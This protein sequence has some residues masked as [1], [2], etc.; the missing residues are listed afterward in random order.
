MDENGGIYLGLGLGLSEYHHVPKKDNSQK[1]NKRV[2]F[3]NLSTPHPQYGTSSDDHELGEDGN[4]GRKNSFLSGKKEEDDDDAN[5]TNMN[6][7]RKK[8]RLTKDQITLLEES[9]KHHPTLN[10]AQ[11]QVLAEKSN[12]KPRQVEVWF[13]NRRAR[14]KLKQ[15]EVDCELL[16]KNCERLS[17]ENW[18]LKKE[19]LELRSSMKMEKARPPTPLPLPFFY[20]ISKAAA[21]STCPSCGGGKQEVGAAAGSMVVVREPKT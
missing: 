2:F 15:T 8:L 18:K 1:N 20:H 14:T 6:C 17:E 16:K 19:L 7:S 3:L 10:T 5:F 13:Q 11:K 12:L 9:F 21:L 4:Q